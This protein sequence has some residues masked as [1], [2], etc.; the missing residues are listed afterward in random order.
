MVGR[1]YRIK[2]EK[3]N[4]TF[5]TRKIKFSMAIEYL[6]LRYLCEIISDYKNSN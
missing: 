6:R 4:N 1:R 2:S 3:E 5:S